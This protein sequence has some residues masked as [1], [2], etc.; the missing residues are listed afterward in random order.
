ME[1]QSVTLYRAMTI[2][3]ALSLTLWAIIWSAF[4]V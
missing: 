1:E 2:N 3:L 4:H